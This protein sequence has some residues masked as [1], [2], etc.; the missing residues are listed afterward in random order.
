MAHVLIRLFI[1]SSLFSVIVFIASS[2]AFSNK[3][4]TKLLDQSKNKSFDMVVVPG[5]PLENGKWD[6]IMK[7]RI[8]WV[9]YLYDHGI[10]KNIM[11]SGSSVYSPY[12]EG[13]VMA[14]YAKAL[15]IP[16]EHIFTETKAEHSTE[17]IYYSYKKAKKLGFNTIALASDPFQTKSLRKFIRKKV[18][19]SVAV[20]PMVMDTMKMIEP[21]MTDPE[22]DY[23]KAYN[24]NFVSLTKREGFWKRLRGTMGKNIDANAYD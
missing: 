15:G 8:Y 19:P 22:I 24:P 5:I 2:C 17:N 12:Y 21:S 3:A 10:A 16:A 20:I 6:R 11:F 14:L 18:D 7:G 23:Q 13:E 1:F 4:A 9:K